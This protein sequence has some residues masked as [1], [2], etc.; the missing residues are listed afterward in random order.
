MYLDF[1]VTRRDTC[2][3]DITKLFKRIQVVDLLQL[4]EL[5]ILPVGISIII[6]KHHCLLMVTINLH[7]KLDLH[8]ITLLLILDSL[9]EA[10]RILIVLHIAADLLPYRLINEV[11]IMCILYKVYWFIEPH[12]LQGF[13]SYIPI[14]PIDHYFI[15]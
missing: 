2:L 15:S 13:P 9:D 7:P 10:V 4:Q 3:S 14:F 12:H 5:S 1:S 6:I 11:I 8:C